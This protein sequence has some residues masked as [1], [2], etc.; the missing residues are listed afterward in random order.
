MNLDSYNDAG[1]IAAVALVNGLTSGFSRGKPTPEVSTA[2]V[3][4]SVL[5]VDPPSLKM[6]NARDTKGFMLL[7]RTLRDVFASLN[8]EDKDAAAHLLNQLLAKYPAT[9]HLAKEDG[10]WRFHHHPAKLA[11]LPMWSSICT[12]GIARVFGMNSAQRLGT[13]AATRCDNVFIDTS[14]NG[15]RRFCSNTCQN[16][17]KTAKFRSRNPLGR[18]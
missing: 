4:T 13:C 5:A 8:S 12:E 10:Q 16:R 1:I 17:M 11:V 7:A 18:G 15:T 14:K 3:I 2:D 9:P 6:F